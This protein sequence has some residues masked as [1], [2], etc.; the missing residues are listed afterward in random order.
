MS[1]DPLT[2]RCEV[3]RDGASLGT[4]TD[5][6]AI[7]SGVYVSLRTDGTHVLFDNLSFTR[8]SR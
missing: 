7:K 4:W 8:E 5:T 6:S 2:S 3:W 1:Y